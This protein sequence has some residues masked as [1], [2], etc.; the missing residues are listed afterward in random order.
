[1]VAMTDMAAMAMPLGLHPGDRIGV[2]SPTP[3]EWTLTMA[4][5]IG[6]REP[7]CCRSGDVGMERK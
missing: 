2:W 3:G 6:Y 5:A 4:A 1:M 7:R